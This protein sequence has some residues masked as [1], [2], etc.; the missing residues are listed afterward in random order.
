M[1]LYEINATIAALWDEAEQSFAADAPP[2]HL[3]Q[4]EAMLKRMEID[5]K[6]KAIGLACMIKNLEAESEALAAE[7]MVL[8]NRRKS[9]E[10]QS[11]WL[12]SYLVGS[13]EPGT[14][15]TSSQVVIS[16]R[17]TQSVQL[18]VAVE[19]LPRQFIREKVTIEPDKLAIREAF[20]SGKA[21]QLSGLAEV[22][23]KKSIQLK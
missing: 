8:R 7:E 12:R 4:I 20:E 22:V 17:S 2:E 5:Q 19:N 14:K 10:R 23:T 9:A 11:E 6:T 3:E 15:I 18:L 13:L 1:K 21:A 16:W